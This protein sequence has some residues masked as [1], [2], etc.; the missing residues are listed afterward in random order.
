[1][2]WAGAARRQGDRLCNSKKLVR[3]S[4][5]A[6]RSVRWRRHRGQAD[7]RFTRLC[8]ALRTGG[9]RSRGLKRLSPLDLWLEARLTIDKLQESFPS[10]LLFY[11]SGLAL[12]DIANKVRRSVRDT[13]RLLDLGLKQVAARLPDSRR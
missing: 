7:L 12:G 3:R 4:H 5:R 6:L 10:V 13:R 9:C 2:S 11:E 1:M 8:G